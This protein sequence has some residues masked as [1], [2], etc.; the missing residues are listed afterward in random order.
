MENKKAKA[1]EKKIDPCKIKACA[2]QRCLIRTRYNYQECRPF[3]DELSE[4]CK[5]HVESESCGFH[6]KEST[7]I[8]I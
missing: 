3:V 8:R 1:P 2:I 4:C 6:D 5:I 7:I